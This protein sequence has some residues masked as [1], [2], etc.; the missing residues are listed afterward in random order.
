MSKIHKLLPRFAHVHTLSSQISLAKCVLTSGCSVVNTKFTRIWLVRFARMTRNVQ[1]CFTVYI[2]VV[3][4]HTP[5]CDTRRNFYLKKVSYRRVFKHKDVY[6][7]QRIK[8]RNQ[9]H[10]NQRH[11]SVGNLHRSWWQICTD[12]HLQ[13]YIACRNPHQPWHHTGSKYLLRKHWECFISVDMGKLNCNKRA[14]IPWPNNGGS[15]VYKKKK[16]IIWQHGC[17]DRNCIKQHLTAFTGW[18]PNQ[19]LGTFNFLFKA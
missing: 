1:I 18:V 5:C 19:K 14:K 10:A 7:N 12:S 3:R 17:S 16:K 4:F 2:H 6:S 11:K 13:L 9:P 15:C 8:Q